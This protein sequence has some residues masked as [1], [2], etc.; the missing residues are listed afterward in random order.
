MRISVLAIIC[1]AVMAV[2]PAHSQDQPGDAD[3]EL[4]KKLANPIASLISVPVQLNYDT[5]FGASDGDKTFVNIQPVIP[6]DLT[7]DLSLVTR[8]ILPIAWQNDIAGN[9]GS[10]AGL[11]DIVQSF[12]FVPQ[13]KETALGS[14]TYGV[15]PVFNWPTS[16]DRLLGS[17]NWGLGPTAVI[18]FQKSG[19]TYG[20]LANHLWGVAETRSSAPD[21]NN[22]FLQPFVSYTTKD[23][24]TFGLNA[25]SSYNWT[26]EDWS[27][28]V[29][30]TISKL[31][32]IGGQRV[33]FTL[34][35]RYWA[36]E[37]DN[38]PDGVG[39]RF[40]VTFLF[41]K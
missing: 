19:W 15:G 24:W 37:P 18:L 35:G 9:S 36:N 7:D 41:P 10:Q 39:V 2:A 23:A 32:S 3:A 26:T 20:G 34:G 21:L 29:N 4:A 1:S 6:F 28:P 33:Q 17:G 27:V 14:L 25:E 40:Q 12:F 8:T 38:G 30:A 11:G 16:T 22:T 5:G 13:S 31:T